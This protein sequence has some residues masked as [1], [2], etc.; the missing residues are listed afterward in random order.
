MKQRTNETHCPVCG[1][2]WEDCECDE[3]YPEQSLIDL[4]DDLIEQSIDFES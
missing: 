4:D 1:K 3:L 2:P